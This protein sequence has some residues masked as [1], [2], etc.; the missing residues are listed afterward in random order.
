MVTSR[1][2]YVY[3]KIL[4][5]CPFVV[6]DFGLIEFSYG[7]LTYAIILTVCYTVFYV[8]AV[9]SRT[10]FALSRES[11]MSII[12]DFSGLSIE[13]ALIVLTWLCF[14]FRQKRMKR[15]ILLFKK[16]NEQYEALGIRR[17]LTKKFL[18]HVKIHALIINAVW[19]FLYTIDH[20]L[21]FSCKEFHL[22]VW[23][24]FNILRVVSRN[25]V[26]MYIYTMKAIE[27]KFYLLNKKI[28]E[29]PYVV[30]MKVIHRE[31]SQKISGHIG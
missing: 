8:R 23:L 2:L 30:S 21:L 22:S 7:G 11:P 1:I 29:L 12:A 26:V 18:N 24:P 14:G 13:F 10:A 16:S 3:W 17:D 31:R 4:G 15:I 25:I 20:L 9:A 27:K 28:Q 5:L 6:N 19:Y